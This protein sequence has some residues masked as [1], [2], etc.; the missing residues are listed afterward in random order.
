M[1]EIII[2]I[3]PTGDVKVEGKNIE[4]PDCKKLTA[5]IEQALGSVQ[6]VKHKPE[7]HRQR[8]ATI[9]RKA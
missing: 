1:Q 4:G 7:F 5:E 3:S 9:T 8:Q 2:E 6:S